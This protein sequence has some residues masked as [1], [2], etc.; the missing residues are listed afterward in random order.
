VRSNKEQAGP[1]EHC[2]ALR[3]I[4]APL[5]CSVLRIAR[6][7]EVLL[8]EGGSVSDAGWLQLAAWLAVEQVAVPSCC[9]CC[10]NSICRPRTATPEVSDRSSVVQKVADR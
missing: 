2:A 3:G 1:G 4:G 6:Q 7:H 9:P 10:N 5:L 8:P